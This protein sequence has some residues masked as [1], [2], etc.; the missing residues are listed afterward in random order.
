MWAPDNCFQWVPLGLRHSSPYT[1]FLYNLCHTRLSLNSTCISKT[2]NDFYSFIFFPIPRATQNQDIKILNVSYDFPRPAS[3]VN[4]LKEASILPLCFHNTMLIIL[5]NSLLRLS[6]MYLSSLPHSPMSYV[7]PAERNCAILI[8][9]D[10]YP[11]KL[12]W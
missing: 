12:T 8:F 2:L 10:L 11:K 6:F 4:N 1:L 9:T 5:W 7:R 3:W